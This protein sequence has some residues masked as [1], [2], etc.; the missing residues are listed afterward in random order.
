M[1]DGNALSACSGL[2]QAAMFEALWVAVVIPAAIPI[3]PLTFQSQ[4]DPATVW[5][6]AG[7]W[8]DMIAE[9]EQS[10]DKIDEYRHT[11]LSRE[12]WDGKD[13]DAFDGKMENFQD[14]IGWSIAVAWVVTACLYVLAVMVGIFIYMLFLIMTLLAIF[15]TAI[16]IAAGTVVGA[17][18]ALELEATANQFAH[19]AYTVLNVSAKAI[20]L[21]SRGVAVLWGGMLAANAIGQW[22]Q[23]NNRV[24]AT[25]G[26]AFVR[27]LDDTLKGSLAWL[28]Q[29]AYGKMFGSPATNWWGK[30]T[31]G[32]RTAGWSNLE[33]I[34]G[35]LGGI[36]VGGNV[37]GGWEGS[38][39]TQLT[40]RMIDW[41]AKKVGLDTGYAGDD[42]E[43]TG[44]N[45][46][47]SPAEKYVERT[48]PKG[49]GS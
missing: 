28:N 5:E 44:P 32:A 25:Y 10:Q 34:F 15:A 27:G 19:M 43:G 33:R 12:R 17:P 13:R 46:K 18:A 45:D 35:G 2:A 23:G 26:N 8:K 16:V 7:G 11:R 3:I 49:S 9:L 30:P 38:A 48:Q 14:Q 29:W 41:G 37:V 31:E 40:D 22:T 1:S 24:A 47:R 39:P 6:G 36:D 42:E 20:E 21:T 4:G